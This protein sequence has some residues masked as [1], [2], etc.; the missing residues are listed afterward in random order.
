[1]TNELQSKKIAFLVAPEGT[2][3]IELVEPWNAVKK[4]GRDP[5]ASLHRPR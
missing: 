1:M 3:Q 4:R 2:E 5:G